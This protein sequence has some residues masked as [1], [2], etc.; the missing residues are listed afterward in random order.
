MRDRSYIHHRR[1]ITLG[2]GKFYKYFVIS[3][4]QFIPKHASHQILVVIMHGMQPLLW[5]HAVRNQPK[6]IPHSR[7]IVH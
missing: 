2:K 1:N 5:Y 7:V 6:L 4:H 3:D